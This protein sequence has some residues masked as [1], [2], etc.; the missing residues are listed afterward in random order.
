M[1]DYFDDGLLDDVFI[2]DISVLKPEY[3]PD[4]ID[5]REDEMEAYVNHLSPVLKGWDTDNIF[6]YGESGVGKTLATRILLP[7]LR[8]KAKENGVEMDIIETNCSGA[9]SSYQA[10]IQIVNETYSPTSPLTTVDLDNQELNNT[11]YPSSMVYNKLFEALDAGGEYLV[12]VLDEIDGIG[13]DGELLYQLTRGQ[14]MG[15]LDAE[16]CVIG[17][18]ND[19]YFKNN[20]KTSVKD[21]L[22]ESEIHF[23]AYN[24]DDL[25]AILERRA[26]QALYDDTLEQGVL[27]LCAALATKEHGSARY[28]IR[29]LRKATRIAE[30]EIRNGDESP[31]EEEGL[32]RFTD[33]VHTEEDIDRVT[34]EHVR[35]AKSIIET[36]TVETGIKKLSNSQRDLLLTIANIHATNNTPTE[37]SEIYN[38]YTDLVEK[39][40]R[41]SISRRGAHNN[42]LSM[43]DKG[44][45]EITNNA[46][47]R[48]G[49][50]NKY[51]LVTGIDTVATALESAEDLNMTL[52]DLRET[53][54]KNSKL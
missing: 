41:S 27:P 42:I 12:L 39:N 9:S 24:H 38:R 22:C 19:L 20:L 10:A 34:E 28:A 15:K 32:D 49:V 13:T 50:P 25:L 46:R 30:D 52:S 26:E 14:S 51:S 16:V 1:P 48:R 36:E 5:E 35:E 43:V 2:K 17:I 31:A 53:A 33:E 21:T 6:L 4:E 7:E 44:I 3:Q 54:Q 18:S 11:G 47:N 29:L 45:I 40:G 23:P 8:E 37:T